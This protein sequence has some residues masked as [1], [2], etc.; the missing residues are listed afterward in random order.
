MIVWCA[1][2]T[3]VCFFSLKSEVFIRPDGVSNSGFHFL[4][5]YVISVRDNE[6]FAE[7][8]HLQCLYPSFNVCCYGPCFTCIQKYGHGQRMHQSDLGA[9]PRST[10][11][12]L[13]SWVF[14]KVTVTCGGQTTSFLFGMTTELPDLT[15]RGS[16]ALFLIY[17]SRAGW[18]NVPTADWLC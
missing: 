3:S 11:T 12:L 4:I 13:S 8:S 10:T 9:W 14:S 18:P 17:P 5:G 7:T 15:S 6:E 2:T 1:C 16:K